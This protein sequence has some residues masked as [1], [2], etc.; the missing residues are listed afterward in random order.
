M[1]AKGL[2]W[3]RDA[4]LRAAVPGIVTPALIVHGDCDPLMPV[5][6]GEWLAAQLPE[7][8]LE[9]F[10]GSAHAPFLADPAHFARALG[11]FCGAP[12]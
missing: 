3:L 12:R 6:A 1:L 9:R 4:D 11:D 10:A 2:D 5:A 7:A 8:R